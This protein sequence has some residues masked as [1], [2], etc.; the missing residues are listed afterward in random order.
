MKPRALFLEAISVVVT[1]LVT[2][3]DISD[4]TLVSHRD[5]PVRGFAALTLRRWQIIRGLKN[6]LRCDSLIALPSPK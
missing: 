2:Q 1:L 4:R 5:H 3:H 6:Q